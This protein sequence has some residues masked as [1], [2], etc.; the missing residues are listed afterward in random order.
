M[1]MLTTLS[2]IG[3]FVATTL[4]A[5]LITSVAYSSEVLPGGYS[6]DV[7]LIAR[8]TDVSIFTSNLL[9]NV[10]E[11]PIIKGEIEG[12]ISGHFT[13]T[14]EEVLNTALTSVQAEWTYI[15]NQLYISPA[16]FE[17]LDGN[18]SL[19]G[20]QPASSKADEEASCKSLVP[21]SVDDIPG[22]NTY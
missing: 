14:V 16:G 21:E 15:D 13:G 22:F 9:E 5:G 3:G 8:N 18:D 12:V 11:Q 20:H 7:E 1:S 19:A 4:L 2:Q 17:E 10:G 6:Q